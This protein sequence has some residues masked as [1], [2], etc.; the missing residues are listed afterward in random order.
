MFCL[1]RRTIKKGPREGE[2]PSVG[3]DWRA[4]R[5]E[6]VTLYAHGI[7]ITYIHFVTFMYEAGF[8]KSLVSVGHSFSTF[9]TCLSIH[10]SFVTEQE[11]FSPLEVRFEGSWMYHLP[12]NHPAHFTCSI[13]V[14]GEIWVLSLQSRPRHL[15][16]SWG[17]ACF[18]CSG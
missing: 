8:S 5:D 3:Q 6:Y 18:L 15:S 12:Q 9:N 16:K 2:D 14:G 1:W 10:V 13:R 17:L 7:I 11:V 4:I